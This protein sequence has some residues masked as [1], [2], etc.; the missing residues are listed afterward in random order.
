MAPG[1]GRQGSS[2]VFFFLFFSGSGAAGS[3]EE[4]DD[5]N[6]GRVRRNTLAKLGGSSRSAQFSQGVGQQ[7]RERSHTRSGRRRHGSGMG[8]RMSPA[9]DSRV[10]VRRQAG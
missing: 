10:V 6:D 3:G 1:K 9:K 5:P 7:E 8:S 4:V 2:S